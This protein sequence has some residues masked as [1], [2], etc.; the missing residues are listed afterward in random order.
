MSDDKNAINEDTRAVT[1]AADLLGLREIDFFRLA[2]RRWFSVD[3]E[4]EQMEKIFANY[5][6]H[7]TVPPWVRHCAREVNNRAGMNMLD[8]AAFGAGDFRQQSKVPKVGRL[9]LMIAG[10]LMLIVYISILTTRHG[11]DDSNCPGRYTNSFYEQWVY[12]INGQQPPPC[13]PDGITKPAP[14]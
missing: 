2:Y 5:M 12:M 7:E 11:F 10:L 6:F 8:P 1:K 9:F 14:Q 4:N 13:E 3:A